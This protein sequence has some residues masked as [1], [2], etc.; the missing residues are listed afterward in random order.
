[1][2]VQAR[3]RQKGNVNGP[4]RMAKARYCMSD[5]RRGTAGGWEE[6]TSKRRR[7]G[8][9]RETGRGATV[10][11]PR[12]DDAL[13]PLMRIKPTAKCTLAEGVQPYQSGRGRRGSTRV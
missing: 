9:P 6:N 8:S 5:G 4:V 7:Q 10:G 1:M 11:L 13:E 12:R 2:R 3:E